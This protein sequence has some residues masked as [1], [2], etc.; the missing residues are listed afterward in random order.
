MKRLIIGTRGSKLALKQ[1]QTVAERLKIL[2]PEIDL[3]IKTIKTK[4]D[5]IWDRS[6]YEIGTKGLFVKEIEEALLRGEIDIAV[7]SMK[8]LPTEI[9]KGLKIGAILERED[10]RDVLISYK[11]KSLSAMEGNTKIGTSSLRRKYQIE[12]LNK[13]IEVLTL[14]GNI[15]TRIKRL[16]EGKFDGIIVAYAAIKRLGYESFI[17]EIIPLETMTPPSGQGAVGIEVRDDSEILDFIR[18]LNDERSYE[19]IIVERKIQSILGG[20]CH[21]PLGVNVSKG[22]GCYVIYIFYKGKKGPVKIAEEIEE[23]KLEA[24]LKGLF[25]LKEKDI[26][27]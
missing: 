4:G 1:T 7:H 6:L 9:P 22:K 19:E 12:I 23:K 21:Q 5:S 26:F 25:S 14:R 13:G 2:Y 18:P 24:F 3:Q 11:F 10:P 16:E 20:G 17:S 8:D 27:S 15:D